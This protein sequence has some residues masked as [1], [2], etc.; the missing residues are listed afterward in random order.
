MNTNVH[1]LEAL[2]WSQHFQMSFESYEKKGGQIAGRISQEFGESYRVYSALGELDAFLSGKLR[3]EGLSGALLPAVGDWVVIEPIAGERKSIIH[4]VLPRRSQFIRKAAGARTEAQ[5]VGANIDTV[6]LVTALDQDFNVRRIERYLVLAWE[7]GARPV[8]V[9]SKSDLCPHLRVKLL[10]VEPVAR[11]VP[12]HAISVVDKTG[13]IHLQQYLKPGIT[14]ALLG[15]SGVGKSTLINELLGFAIQAVQ[16]VR[17][18]D[19]KGRHTTTRRELILLPS[20]GLLLDTPGMRELQLWEAETGL[21]SAFEEIELLASH[22]RFR[23]CTHDAEP[24]CAV[25]DALE[26]EHLDARRYRSYEK[27]RREIKHMELKQDKMAL[28]SEKERWKKLTRTGAQ[29]GEM[30]RKGF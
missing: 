20:G 19:G 6:F 13:L 3:F 28:R 10:E 7:S 5:I 12:I 1:P 15:S 2:G 8:I 21:E 11:D 17:E 9:L 18:E 26:N 25:R 23:D 16:P 24:D 29:R 27:L 22:C 14:A 30:K 4:S